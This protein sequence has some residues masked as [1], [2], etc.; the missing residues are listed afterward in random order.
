LGSFTFGSNKSGPRGPD[1]IALLSTIFS[2][3]PRHNWDVYLTTR[4]IYLFPCNINPC[5][6]LSAMCRKCFHA[7]MVFNFVGTK[8]LLQS[9]A[10]GNVGYLA[11]ALYAM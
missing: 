4:Q 11:A 2:C 7:P 3:I 10:A 1:V 6:V 9:L 5:P 8:N